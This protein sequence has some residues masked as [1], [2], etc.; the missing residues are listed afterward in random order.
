MEITF[1]LNSLR[2]GADCEAALCRRFAGF[3][4]AIHSTRF[5]GH[6]LGLARAAAL[7][8]ADTVVA[9]GG[10]GTVSEVTNGIAGTSAALGIIPCGTANDFAAGLGL[11]QRLSDACAVI[12]AGRMAR[13]DLLSVNG[14]YF[15]SAGGVGLACEALVGA[16]ARKR[17]ALGRRL[18]SGI[19]LL[20]LIHAFARRGTRAE[21]V[22]ILSG[23][24]RLER[25]VSMVLM[26]NQPRLGRH[27]RV[28]PEARLQSGR[29]HLCWF[30]AVRSALQLGASLWQ[31]RRGAHLRYS[32]VATLAAE[33]IN[34]E[35]ERPLS[36]FVDGELQPACRTLRLRAHPRALT[37]LAP[38][39]KETGTSN[40]LGGPTSP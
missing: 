4:I 23:N 7:A 8:G 36:F 5:G 34:L 12:K 16:E 17:H 33:R 29:V 2:V 3:D 19:Y 28:S 37:V 21:R 27:F 24:R 10:D 20:G 15:V 14:R 38:A 6:A 1:V 30:E 32:H 18:G 13:V 11:P 25:R 31:A 22:S 9:V 26:C 39:A 35:C 40:R